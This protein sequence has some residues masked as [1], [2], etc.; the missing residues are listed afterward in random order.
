MLIETNLVRRGLLAPRAN[1]VY[2]LFSWGEK[3]SRERQRPAVSEPSSRPTRAKMSG[4]LSS[5]ARRVPQVLQP[6]RMNNLTIRPKML[7]E[8]FACKAAKERSKEAAG[9]TSFGLN[10]SSFLVHA[11]WLRSEAR[12]MVTRSAVRSWLWATAHISYP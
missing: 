11:G 1:R 5:A 7:N 4:S 9:L 3:S 12:S 10:Q 8:A 2:R 6:H